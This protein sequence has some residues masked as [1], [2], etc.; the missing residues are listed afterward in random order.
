MIPPDKHKNQHYCIA[1]P[2]YAIICQHLVLNHT[3]PK[4]TPR[5]KIILDTANYLIFI[6]ANFLPHFA[7]CYSSSLS[8][9][10]F[11]SFLRKDGA[12]DLTTLLYHRGDNTNVRR[13]AKERCLDFC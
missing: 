4:I 1:P 3:L 12:G 13:G 5:R 2:K 6:A 9:Q 8:D 11:S 10:E 7:S